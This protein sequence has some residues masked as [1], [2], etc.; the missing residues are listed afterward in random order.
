MYGELKNYKAPPT[1]HVTSLYI[2]G[3]KENLQKE[4][5]KSF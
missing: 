5:Y 2:G 4:I 3:K 1:L